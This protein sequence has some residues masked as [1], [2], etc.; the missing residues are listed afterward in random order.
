VSGYGAEYSGDG[1]SAWTRVAVAGPS[2]ATLA[3]LVNNL[4]YQVRVAAVNACGTGPFAAAAGPTVPVAPT[5][6]GAG[7]LVPATP[8]TATST[9]AGAPRPAT[10]EVVQDTVLRLSTDAITLRL[11]ALD[12]PGAAIPVDSTRTVLLEQGGRAATD[13]VGFTPGSYVTAYLYAAGRAPLL[14]GAV[15]VAQDGSFA[16]S[17]PVPDTL[18]AGDYTLQVNGVDHTATPRAVGIG[19]EVAGPP[20]ELELAAT[21][22]ERA[23]AAGDTVTITLVV[24]NVGRGPAVDVVIPRAFREPGFAV[25]RA[26]PLEGAYNAATH[27]WAI[28]RIERGAQA[29]LRLTAVV[30]P[31][32]ATPATQSAAPSAAPAPSSAPQPHQP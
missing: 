3:G 30:L 13:G 9:A 5:R 4:G 20:P 8:G 12:A 19:V 10:L 18:A 24:T 27:D 6:D 15:P 26:A 7:Q 2:P 16:A 23:P 1:G 17:L 25:V 32:D 14:L 11:R 21:P 31:P 22:D 29:R 28:R